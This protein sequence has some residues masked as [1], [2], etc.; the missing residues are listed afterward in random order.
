M[1]DKTAVVNKGG[2][3]FHFSFNPQTED[4][5]EGVTLTGIFEGNRRLRPSAFTDDQIPY[6]EANKRL[7]K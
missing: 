6:D 2:K 5:S 1:S 4:P 3:E 7:I